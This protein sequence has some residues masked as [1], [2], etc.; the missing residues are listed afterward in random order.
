M[1]LTKLKRIIKRTS[2]YLFLKNMKN[3]YNSY[4]LIEL[5]SKYSHREKDSIV[6]GP[7]YF[8]PKLVELYEQT[9]IS[10]R[11]RLISNRGK[12]IV[13]KYSA[14][15]ADC[16]AIT[17]NHKST[18]S[19]PHAWLGRSHVNDIERD[20]IVEEDVW[21]GYGVTLLSG[22]HLGRGCICAARS[23]INKNIPP[24]AVVAGSPAKIIAVK[25]SKEQIIA[26]ELYLYSKDERLSEKY[27]DELFET[28]F[29][30]LKVFG[31]DKIS[32]IDKSKVEDFKLRNGYDY[33]I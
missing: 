17:Q 1:D 25:F 23:L 18:V 28:Y 9:R 26:H 16:T 12:F 5:F 10:T 14:I 21:V 31:T 29:K 8:N 2:V 6:N 7:C 15:A 11:F 3:I 19:I 13:K 33:V 27:I 4:F 32:D 24:Y 20:I 22:A 30:G